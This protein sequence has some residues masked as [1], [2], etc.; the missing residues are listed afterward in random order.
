MND[1]P[2]TIEIKDEFINK[3]LLFCRLELIGRKTGEDDGKMYLVWPD[4][5]AVN[6]VIDR[7]QSNK[8]VPIRDA[9]DVFA[10]LEIWKSNLHAHLA[11]K[12]ANR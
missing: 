11:E 5:E 2:K 12:N 8:P 7:Y 9:R 10:G 6:D 1:Q 4:T 3:A